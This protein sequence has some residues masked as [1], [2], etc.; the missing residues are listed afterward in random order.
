M[1]D[2][3]ERKSEHRETAAQAETQVS[4]G[5]RNPVAALF[6]G[7]RRDAGPALDWHQA[8]QGSG[9]ERP[10]E[11]PDGEPHLNVDRTFVFADL[12]GFTQF[13]RTHGPHESVKLLEEFR[14]ITREVAAKRGV[15]VAKWLGDG[16]MIVS[17]DPTAAVAFGAH[18]IHHFSQTD[19]Q[20]RVGLASGIALL[21]EG[22][23]YI[24]EPVNL[25]AKLCSAAQ[26]DEIL[27]AIDTDVLPDWVETTSDVS[28]DIRGIGL[29]RD[30]HRLAP[31][32]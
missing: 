15:R 28:V 31:V 17:V 24:G 30:I 26:P 19:L 32:L 4:D 3:E 22:D 11:L 7:R 1:D 18:L 16:V 25:A 29:I 12:S 27:A 13:T 9:L 14:H 23:D 2:V 21:F 10:D 5:S 8:K 6:R 20:V